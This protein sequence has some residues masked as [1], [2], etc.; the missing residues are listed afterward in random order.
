MLRPASSGSVDNLPRAS[1]ALLAWM[2][3]IPGSPLFKAISRSRDSASR[4]SPTTSRSGRIRSASLISRRSVISPVPSRL[5]WRHCMATV[6][7]R[8]EGELE[9]LLDRHDPVGRCGTQRSARSAASSCHL[10]GAGDQDVLAGQHAIRRN[11]AAW[12][13][14]EPE[15]DQIV[16]S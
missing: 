6:S 2:V 12:W 11:S 14:S 7:R 5:G 4:T 1:L 8:T 13:V 9:D 3:H 15:L 16:R 10:G